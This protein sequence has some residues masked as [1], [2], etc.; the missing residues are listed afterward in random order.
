MIEKE[1][2]P[3]RLALT[4]L[5]VSEMANFKGIIDIPSRA[6]KSD[7]SASAGD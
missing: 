7:M 2:S 5:W 6:N 1:P 3:R 4:A